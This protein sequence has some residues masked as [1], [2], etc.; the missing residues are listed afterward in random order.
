M[1][2][3]RWGGASRSQGADLLL[4]VFQK[5][6]GRDAVQLGV[7]ELEGDGQKGPEPMPA[8]SAPDQKGVIVTAGVEV[9]GS[10]DVMTMA[11]PLRSWGWP[12]WATRPVS[13]K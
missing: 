1:E 7:V 8:V 12:V 4:K 9:D 13:S 11:S 2:K 3:I 6:G 10:V 5:L